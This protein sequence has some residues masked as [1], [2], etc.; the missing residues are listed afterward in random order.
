MLSFKFSVIINAFFIS[1]AGYYHLETKENT[2]AL[3]KGIGLGNIIIS[4]LCFGISQGLNGALETLV[5]QAY[6]ASLNL[7]ETERFRDEMR[8][9]CGQYLNI[10]RLVNTLFMIAPTAILALFADEILITFFKQDAYISELAIQY[11]ILCMPGV[12]AMTQFDATKRFL[13]AQNHGGIPMVT[14]FITGGI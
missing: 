9:L 14:Q 6:G 1:L 7:K 5:S 12:W 2:T 8:K 3:I 4:I 10:A 13:S 11:C